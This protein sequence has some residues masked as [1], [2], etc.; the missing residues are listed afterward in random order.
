MKILQKVPDD[1]A[2]Y[3]LIDTS[4]PGWRG[5][6]DSKV[7][8]QGKIALSSLF[9]CEAQEVEAQIAGYV[10]GVLAVAGEGED[11]A[12]GGIVRAYLD[13]VAYHAGGPGGGGS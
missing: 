11:S 8:G 6:L 7:A 3:E 12:A 10:V 13:P 9:L 4:A 2:S 5:V 1:D